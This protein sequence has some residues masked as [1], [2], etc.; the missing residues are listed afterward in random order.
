MTATQISIEKRSPG[1]WRATF[2]HPPINLIDLQTIHELDALVSEIETDPDVRVVVFDSADRDFFLAHFDVLVDKAALSALKPGRTGLH[3]W[4]DVL[5]RLSSAPV[6]S[7]ASIRGRA[8][9]AGSEFALA[10]DVR[11]GSREHCILAQFEVGVGAVPGGG[12]MARLSRLVGRGR[13]IEI[14]AGAQ[15]FSG[16]LAAQYGYINRALQDDELDEFVEAFARRLSNF[17]K[18]AIAEVKRLVDGPTLP[19]S[20]E[21]EAGMKAYLKSTTRPDTRKRIGRAVAAGLQQRGEVE[22]FLGRYVA[23]SAAEYPETSP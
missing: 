12:P 6:V 22:L 20:S 5:V 14:V 10:C 11:F 3:P 21:L 15:D 13:A 8:R 7:V 16:E 1:Y 23:E 19:T 18:Q 4:L 9:G 17:D 2:D